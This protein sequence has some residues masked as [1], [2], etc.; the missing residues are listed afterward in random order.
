MPTYNHAHGL[1]RIVNSLGEFAQGTDVELRV[2]DDSS[3]DRAAEEIETI[4][5]TCPRGSYKRN[6]PSRGAVA[7]WNGL[8]DAAEGEYCQLVHHDEYFENT[9]VL[10]DALELLRASPEFDGV[11]FPCRVVSVGFP[12]GRLHLPAWLARWIVEY[13]PGYMLRRNP[14]AAPSTLLLRRACYPRYDERLRWL[15]DCE[16]YVRAIV[17]H[18][19]TL[20]FMSGPG[21]LSDGTGVESITASLGSTVDKVKTDELG[22]LVRQGLPRARGAWLVSQSPA[23]ALARAVESVGWTTFRAIQRLTQM[24]M[25]G[26]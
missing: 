2:H 8:L 9:Q 6:V 5:R 23:A 13:F 10:R 3:D 24:L 4:V 22:L 16:L 26:R 20:K 18:R 14:I 21:V 11:V 25:R 12:R 1:R 7:N 19:P 15:V 17:I